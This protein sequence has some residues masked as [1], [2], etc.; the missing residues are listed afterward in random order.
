MFKDFKEFLLK[1]HAIALAIGVIIGAGIGKLVAAV[2]DDVINPV[3][4]LLL[5][6]GDW[7]NAK[8]VLSHATDAAGKVTENAIAYGDLIGRVVDFMISLSWCTDPGRFCEARADDDRSA[9]IKEAIR[10]TPGLKPARSLNRREP[11]LASFVNPATPEGSPHETHRLAFA[12]VS[13]PVTGTVL[14]EELPPAGPPV[15]SGKA[16]ASYVGTTGNTNVQTVGAGLEIDYKDVW[17]GLAKAPSSG[18]D[19]R[20]DDGQDHRR[21]RGGRHLAPFRALRPGDYFKNEFAGIDNGSRPWGRVLGR[22]R[23]PGTKFSSAPATRR[24]TARS[25]T[26]SRSGAFRPAFSTSGRSPR[27]PT[28]RKNSPTSTASRIRATGGSRTRS[29]SASRSTRSSR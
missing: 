4:G 20:R 29:R 25:A 7:R 2:A 17:D 28:S 13:I 15:W 16:E 19:G 3:I 27:R 6:A 24:R 12:V 26:T 1:Q 9:P 22:E 14:A 23:R 21:S 8:I 5:P 11:E 18:K 10:R